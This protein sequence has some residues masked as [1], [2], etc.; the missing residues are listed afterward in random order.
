MG[1]SKEVARALFPDK[2]PND[3]LCRDFAPLH[4][5]KELD[6]LPLFEM[7]PVLSMADPFDPYVERLYPNPYH[8][9]LERI[10]SFKQYLMGHY[11]QSYIAYLTGL[12]EKGELPLGKMSWLVPNPDCVIV[13]EADVQRIDLFRKSLD[14]VYADIIMSVEV[15][16]SAKR[17]GTYV[18]DHLSQWFRV[19]T[20]SDLSLDGL[21]F[22]DLICIMIYDRNEP[23][24]GRP[25]DEYLV[26]YTSADSLD[27]ESTDVLAA[28]FP[29][30]L[31]RPCRVDGERLAERMALDVQYYRLTLDCAIRGQMYFES[32][33]IT[34][35]NTQ[36]QPLKKRIPA[37]TIVVDL[38]TCTDDDGSINKE[39][40]N[41]TVIHE[42]YHAYKHKLFYLGQ[43]LYNQEIR[44]LSCSVSGER[45]GAVIDTGFALRDSL[46]PDEAYLAEKSF[47]SRSPVDWIEWQANRATPRIRMPAPTTQ[48]KIEELIAKY[49]QR[50]PNM[51]RTKLISHVIGD[52][53][54]FYGV[55]K[56]SAKLRMIELG[57]TEA[58]GVLNYVN[59][60]YVADHSFAPGSLEKNQ[61]FSIDFY[62]ALELFER[63]PEF[64]QCLSTG[65]YQYIDGHFCRNDPRYVYRRNGK[66]HLSS[67]AKNHMDECCLIFTMRNIGPSY[68]YR[69]G[70]LLRE[71]VEA[72]K[73]ADYTGSGSASDILAESRRLS[74]IIND[75]PMSPAG[76]LVAHMNRAHMTVEA[77]VAKTGVSERTIMRLRKDAGYKP[78]K[79]NALAICVGLQLEP[80]LRRDWLAKIGQPLTN[81][82]TDI[83]Y[84]L[85][86]SS[87]YLQPV[88]AVN[89]KL[90]ECG[91]PPLSKCV[92]ELDC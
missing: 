21:S 67:Y 89:E 60:G 88:S 51:Q 81:S 74:E 27:Y 66:L 56:Q 73:I 17:G 32:R 57:Y 14:E 29:E 9:N 5:A 46:N 1:Q 39:K 47:M 84:D 70:T 50:Y 44:C 6:R 11:Y 82:Q 2:P 69:E 65:L 63:S 64:Q 62:T 83:L 7:G 37:N 43:R 12:L 48:I 76:T 68:R 42:C 23:A 13:K 34:V 20:C 49:S 80:M 77:L 24:P 16:V 53:A 45:A 75:L 91:L 85:L 72:Q 35:L 87:M 78:S 54:Q 59:G 8:N 71:E 61:T 28:F 31:S 33:E 10:G 40:L 26:P 22:N 55:S 86:L 58:Q 3:D 90:Q 30:A 18:K 4:L 15:E 79:G 36:G 25:L 92:D 19:R 38:S 52:L 41:D